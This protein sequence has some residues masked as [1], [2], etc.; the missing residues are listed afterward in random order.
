[1]RVNA[2]N[3]QLIMETS[4][5]TIKKTKINQSESLEFSKLIKRRICLSIF[6]E[7]YLKLKHMNLISFQVSRLECE[8]STFFTMS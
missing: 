5:D 8:F 7:K 6:E 1:M 2:K 3:D 4:N